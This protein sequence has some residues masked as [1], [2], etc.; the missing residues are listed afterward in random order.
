MIMVE[1]NWISGWK[2][3]QRIH[4]ISLSVIS[5]SRIFIQGLTPEFTIEYLTYAQHNSMILKCMHS[6]SKKEERKYSQLK[7]ILIEFYAL[8]MYVSVKSC[9]QVWS[10]HEEGRL[11]DS[12]DRTCT[13]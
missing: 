3:I 8:Q 1:I 6:C 9:I 13:L 2:S 5:L 7:A 12:S 10:H 11:S 4:E